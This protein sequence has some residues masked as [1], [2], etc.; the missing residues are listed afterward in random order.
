MTV[1][2]SVGLAG[3]TSVGGIGVIVFGISVKVGIGVLVGI[4]TA[5]D[6]GR[7][8]GVEVLLECCGAGRVLVDTKKF[9]AGRLVAVFVFAAVLEAV[10]VAV[11]V[12]VSVFVLSNSGME[13][14]CAVC[15]II[16]L[17]LEMTKSIT[18]TVGVPKG[19]ALLISLMPTAAAPHNKLMPRTPV[20]INPS[21]GK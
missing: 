5:V 9:M 8:M 1:G 15:T 19:T 7:G 16:V 4:T 10:T 18:P 12:D 14:A 17:I 21:S 20:R 11:L 13:K 2:I 6:V 3:G